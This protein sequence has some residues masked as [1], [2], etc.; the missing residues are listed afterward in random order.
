MRQVAGYG[1][2]AVTGLGYS[3]YSERHVFIHDM[4]DKSTHVI[5]YGGWGS[6]TKMTWVMP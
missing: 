2:H 6:G 4:Y 3:D 5:A 1:N